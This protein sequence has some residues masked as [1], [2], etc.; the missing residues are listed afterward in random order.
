V[1]T[2]VRFGRNA[3]N[4][5]I[6]LNQAPTRTLRD[7]SE[8]CATVIASPVEGRTEKCLGFA[9]HKASPGSAAVASTRESVKSSLDPRTTLLGWGSQLEYNAAPHLAIPTPATF[10]RGSVQV[11]ETVDHQ[12]SH[13]HGTIVKA[14]QVDCTLS[15]LTVCRA[16]YLK[17]R[18]RPRETQGSPIQI[19]VLVE[20]RTAH[21]GPLQR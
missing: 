1:W 19:P 3:K 7:H 21:A 10:T 20:D 17:D 15:E 13:G 11:S 14:E 6:A 2:G 18:T 5:S 4:T 9:E 8:N 12:T 16:R